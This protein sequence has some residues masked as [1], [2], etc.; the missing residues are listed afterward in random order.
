MDVKGIFQEKMN[1]DFRASQMC[2]VLSACIMFL[3]SE[4]TQ[5]GPQDT[6]KDIEKRKAK[7]EAYE[8]CIS[9]LKKEFIELQLPFED[10]YLYEERIKKVR[11]KV[12]EKLCPIDNSTR[13]TKEYTLNMCKAAIVADIIESLCYEMFD[14]GCKYGGNSESESPGN[15]DS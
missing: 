10:Q 11:D 15:T 8:D 5:P 6:L 1:N 9:I 7:I 2:D 12:V 4:N 3:E 13:G 14:I